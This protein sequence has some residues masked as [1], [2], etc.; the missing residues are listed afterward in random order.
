MNKQTGNEIAIEQQ[1]DDIF[2]AIQMIRNEVKELR[3]MVICLQPDLHPSVKEVN[4]NFPPETQEQLP[5]LY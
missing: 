3:T 4:E 1:L 5:L 2:D